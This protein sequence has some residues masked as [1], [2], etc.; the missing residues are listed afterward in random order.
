MLKKQFRE[1]CVLGSCQ[2]D[3]FHS[4][5]GNSNST[6]VPSPVQYTIIP[7]SSVAQPRARSGADILVGQ[8]R[9]PPFVRR[10]RLHLLGKQKR[11][12]LF[13]Y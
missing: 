6:V 11:K 10:L 2:N 9:E 7:I 5:K 13:F 3:L 8:S 4:T 12:V 1:P